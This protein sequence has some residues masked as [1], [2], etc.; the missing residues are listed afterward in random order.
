MKL[1]SI[2]TRLEC[3]AP[4]L[5]TT[6]LPPAVTQILR[7][8]LSMDILGSQHKLAD[9]WLYL[10]AFTAQYV[11]Q[12]FMKAEYIHNGTFTLI[13]DHRSFIIVK[14]LA[15]NRKCNILKLLP[16]SP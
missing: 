12:W 9:V 13:P 2:N 8:V 3:D 1:L 4:P 11:K 15:M 5:K 16:S 6:E 10:L 7:S 14:V